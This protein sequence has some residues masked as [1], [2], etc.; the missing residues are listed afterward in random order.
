[1]QAPKRKRRF[2]ADTANDLLFWGCHLAIVAI[3]LGIMWVKFDAM[4]RAL[5]QLLTAQNNELDVARAEALKTEEAYNAARRAEQQRSIDVQAAQASLSS[6]V[7]Q[8]RDNQASIKT[9]Q[10]SIKTILDTVN[11]TNQLVLRASQQAQAAA[12]GS[13]H[14]AKEAAGDAMAAAGAASTAAKRVGAAA[15]ISGR[16]ANVVATK[17][18]T[19]ADKAKIQAQEKVLA[20]KQ[21]Q[22]STTIL[23]VKKQGPTLWDKLIH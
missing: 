14:A 3:S 8:V 9:N 1:M 22:L 12:I 17:V 4:N 15:A 2:S 6:L 13:E 16:T 20:K 7:L 21:E 11:E 23:R 10:N 18:V 19:S 5:K